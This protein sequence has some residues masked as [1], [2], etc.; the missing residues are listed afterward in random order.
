MYYMHRGATG[1]NITDVM[2]KNLVIEGGGVLGVALCGALTELSARGKLCML[3]NF[4]GSSAGAIVAGALACEATVE[5]ITESMTDVDFSS[6]LDYGNRLK[7]G[8]NFCERLGA[9]SGDTFE[10]WYG[11]KLAVLTGDRNITLGTVHELY[12]GTLIITATNVNLRRVEYFSWENHPDLPLVRAVRMSMSIPFL[13]EP[14]TFNGDLWVDGGTMDNFPADA[15][16]GDPKHTLGIKLSTAAETQRVKIKNIIN[17]TG[18]VIDC[19]LRSSQR[20]L[21]PHTIDICCGN[22]SSTDFRIGMKEKKQ[23]LLAGKRAATEYLASI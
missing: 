10:K 4:A 17:Y 12:G 16:S 13:F 11:D 9:C 6:F 18:A 19:V 5:F 14:V 8:Y 15:F 23:L 22:S 2:Y 20:E 21:L 3:T 7:A 1:H